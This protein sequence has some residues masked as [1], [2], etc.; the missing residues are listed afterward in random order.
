[1][2]TQAMSSS[3]FTKF[4]T[5]GVERRRAGERRKIGRAAEY[6]AL[7][8]FALVVG[9]PWLPRDVLVLTPPSVG[10]EVAVVN[11]MSPPVNGNVHDAGAVIMTHDALGS[12]Q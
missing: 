6:V 10:Y 11:K 7:L 8:Y 12:K 4:P 2:D 3:E 9:A 5:P 1:M